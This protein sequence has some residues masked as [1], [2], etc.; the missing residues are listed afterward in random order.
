MENPEENFV[1]STEPFRRELLALCYRMTGSTEEAQDLVQETY[2]RAWRSYSR[3]EGRSSV[4]TWLY[5]IA[6]NVCFTALDSRAIR[7]CPA[8]LPSGADAE[9]PWVQ[10]VPDGLILSSREDLHER[11]AVR[12]SV[13]L[14]LVAALQYLP[15][16]QR[17]LLILSDVLDWSAKEAAL[18]LGT[19]TA[20]VKSALQ[21]AR[22]RLQTIAP[23]SERVSESSP[24]ENHPLLQGYISAFE[25]SDPLALEAVLRQD[26]RLELPP[27]AVWYTGREAIQCA[28]G[29]LGTR[30]DWKLVPTVANGQPAAGAYHREGGGYAPF[31][32]VVLT[33]E[34]PSIVRIS[35]FADTTLFPLFSLPESPG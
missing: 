25:T 15:P 23:T 7:R 11:L 17:A 32:V 12:E 16:R 1:A 24:P 5:R 14:A 2:L 31:A 27:S 18:A 29:A 10:P 9:G 28:T 22:A 20:A 3:F 35:V 6:T 30:G 8:D 21:R 33:I 26:V 34:G 4:R 13:R 19:T